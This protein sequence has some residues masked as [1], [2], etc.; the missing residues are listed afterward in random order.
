MSLTKLDSES[1]LHILPQILDKCENDKHC[2]SEQYRI[3]YSRQK[4]YDTGP[5]LFS[6]RKK[7]P[8]GTNRQGRGATLY[9]LSLSLP[10]SHT[11]TLS[12]SLSLYLSHTHSHTH[13]RTLSLCR[14]VSNTCFLCH[15][16]GAAE[17]PLFPIFPL[18]A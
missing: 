18:S 10:L 14:T 12:P 11:H 17:L 2:S 9:S 15:A 1:K 4:F 8:T 5:G 13:T 6:Q 7:K 16:V 3:N